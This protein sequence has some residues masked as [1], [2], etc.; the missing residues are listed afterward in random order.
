MT[1]KKFEWLLSFARPA[2]GNRPIDA[3][4]A[5]DVLRVLKEVEARGVHETA[6]KLRT[7]IG[8]VL[9]SPTVAP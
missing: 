6:R 7:A 9:V 4:S 3:I 8:E 1:L 2:I 5:R